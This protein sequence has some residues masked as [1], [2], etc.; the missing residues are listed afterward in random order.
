MECVGLWECGRPKLRG[1]RE[2]DSIHMNVNIS[3][4]V[5]SC[6][7]RDLQ[8]VTFFLLFDVLRG[9]MQDAAH[10][11]PSLFARAARGPKQR[12]QPLL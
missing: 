11:C 2:P 5:R 4:N 7:E 6:I 1:V 9:L 8:D 10:I 12:D 3:G